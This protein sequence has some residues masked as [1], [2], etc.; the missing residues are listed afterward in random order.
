MYFFHS[1]DVKVVSELRRNGPKWNLVRGLYAYYI[2]SFAAKYNASFHLFPS[3]SG[4][5]GKLLPNKT[6][7][8]V[9][10]DIYYGRADIGMPCGIE[11]AR[12]AVVS[13][14][15]PIGF[16]RL[17]FFTRKPLHHFSWKA[18]YRPL[19]WQSWM[20]ALISSIMALFGF[21]GLHRVLNEPMNTLKVV[22]YLFSTCLEQ[23]QES[24]FKPITGTVVL[25]IQLI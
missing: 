21:I 16:D 12:S 18:V 24:I 15:H 5:T 11:Y 17:V 1:P 13:F 14:T 7:T 8:G 23:M 20:L 9:I 19:T 10:G 2:L 25:F 4:G 6:W 3:S 22:G